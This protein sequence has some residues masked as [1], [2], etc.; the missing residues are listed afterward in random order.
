MIHF[1]QYNNINN[2]IINGDM[3]K[4]RSLIIQLLDE[5]KRLKLP[6]TSI[7]NHLIRE[8]GL[9]PYID[10]N[11]ASWEDVFAASMFRTNTSIDE[12]A[13]L[14]IE[15]AYILKR[16]LQGESLA[17]SAP[18]SFGKSYIIDSF[19]AL[20]KPNCVVIIVP[21][22][23]L[24]NETRRRL[25]KKFSNLY[26]IITTSD[27]IV[28]EKSILI[29]PQERVFSYLREIK[30][31]DI[32]I[33]DEFYKAS[34][35]DERAQ[36]LLNAMI[37]LGKL[38]KQKYY[39][40]PNID[41]IVENPFTNDMQFVSENDFKTVV[42]KS[43][44]V[45]LQ[46]NKAQNIGTFKKQALVDILTESNSKALIYAASHSQVNLVCKILTQQ[47]PL[48]ISDLCKSFTQ[49]LRVNYGSSCFLIPLIE[50]GIGAHNGNLHRSLAQIQ[51]KLFEEKCGLDTIVSTSSI[52]EGVNTQAERVILWNNKIA[53]EPLD[54]F[55]YRNIIGRAGRMFKYFIGYVY[56]LEEAPKEKPTQ[57]DFP[58]TDDVVCNLDDDEPGIALNLQQKTK[59]QNYNNKLRS[60]LGPRVFSVI[61]NNPSIKGFSPSLVLQLARKI[62]SDNRWPAEFDSLTTDNTYSWRQPIQ[63][64]FEELKDIKTANRVKIGLWIFSDNWNKSIPCLVQKFEKYNISAADV[65]RLERDITYRIPTILSAIYTIKSALYENTAD[66]R[67]FIKR[68]TNAFLPKN[69][70]ELEEYG[71][72]RMLSK[73]I[74]NT[75]LID[76]E[77][78]SVSISE[79]IKKLKHIGIDEILEKC[80][81]LHPFDEYILKYFFDGI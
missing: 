71:L 24:A 65:F 78:E 69:V 56:L 29:L 17:V 41:H 27:E 63:E 38:S 42:T 43:K 66:I 6:N 12:F 53:G 50:R 9:F 67:P 18:T 36:R 72:P 35:N 3:A 40:G 14:H 23:A 11:T 81:H 4:A 1:E 58:L 75:N 54:Y 39:L 51:I 76:L 28:G 70:Y 19:I 32:L 55:T 2:Y 33:V 8:V 13:I 26:S 61:K 21:T 44:R 25:S 68:A 22:I 30:S 48:S 16:L 37:E 73:K 60:I 57:I 47:L 5:R 34:L 49:W 59:L 20:K 64:I 45:Y 80:K 7:L 77:D 79:I 52:I 74:H 31:I 15:Q 10:C 62:V 46:K